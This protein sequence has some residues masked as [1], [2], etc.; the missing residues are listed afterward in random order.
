[1]LNGFLQ[2]MFPLLHIRQLFAEQQ[3]HDTGPCALRTRSLPRLPAGG[4]ERVEW[5][6]RRQ[7][8]VQPV[9]VSGPSRVICS[10]PH[11]G[12][13]LAALFGA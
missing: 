3:Q 2:Q 13:K 12:V 10:L 9:S 4:A 6:I 11:P 1:M 8:L 7:R 5:V